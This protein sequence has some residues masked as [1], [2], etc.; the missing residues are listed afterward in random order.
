[1]MLPEPIATRGDLTNARTNDEAYELLKGLGFP[2][3]RDESPN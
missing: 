3:Q 2:F 1:M